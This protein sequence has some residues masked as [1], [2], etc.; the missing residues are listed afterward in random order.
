[1]RIGIWFTKP[2]RP[3]ATAP[4]QS[5]MCMN[6]LFQLRA[7]AIKGQKKK[8]ESEILGS[9]LI[10]GLGA[11][12]KWSNTDTQDWKDTGHVFNNLCQKLP[13][14]WFRRYAI[15]VAQE[16]RRDWWLTFERYCKPQHNSLLWGCARDQVEMVVQCIVGLFWGRIFNM[17]ANSSAKTFPQCTLTTIST[18]SP[19]QP[20]SGE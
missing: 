8:K 7:V 5:S 4:A 9:F 1:M 10:L 19:A 18:R 16:T 3:I 17:A 14:Q 6:D 13:L 2:L 11:I 20:Q 15:L 12:T